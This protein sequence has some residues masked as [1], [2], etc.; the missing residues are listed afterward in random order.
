MSWSGNGNPQ[1]VGSWGEQV[2]GPTLV[3]VGGIHGNEPSG[4]VALTRL[5]Q[6]LE[7]SHGQ[8]Q[9]RLVGP[10]GNRQALDRGVR[11]IHQDL[12]R[13]W[14]EEQLDWIRSQ[15]D[16]SQLDGERREQAR[17]LRVLEQLL[18]T[19][20]EG[21]F[22]LLDLHSTSAKGAPFSI[23]NDQPASQR[24]AARFPVPMVFGLDDEIHGTLVSYFDSR[25]I[26]ALGFEGGA[27]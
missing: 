6:E 21:R 5:L 12:N 9:G 22:Y 17:L 14:T 26:P 11:W 24:L 8:V 23:V 25:G 1:V 13:L 15:A 4:V 27:A 10:R 18:S 2:R 7:A 16:P 3:V 19:T 20:P